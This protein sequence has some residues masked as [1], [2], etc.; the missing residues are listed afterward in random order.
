[1]LVHRPS[2]RR[3]QSVTRNQSVSALAQRANARADG[4]PGCAEA[5]RSGHLETARRPEVARDH[6]GNAPHRRDGKHREDCAAMG[7]CGGGRLRGWRARSKAAASAAR[8]G[9]CLG[10]SG[11]RIRGCATIMDPVAQDNPAA[12]IELDEAFEAKADLARK[13]PTLYKP[14]R[15]N[16]TR[17]VTRARSSCDRST[18]WFTASPAT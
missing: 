2:R 6:A 8:V 15:V 10:A 4:G 11:M 17:H 16:D 9:F 13:A 12:A 3:A 1:M 18:S 14:A 7:S 5:A